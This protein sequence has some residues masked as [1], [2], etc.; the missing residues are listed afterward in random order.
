M[1]RS[2]AISRSDK[3]VGSASP[4][5]AG[6]LLFVTAY[7]R[8]A[9]LLI[10]ALV[11]LGLIVGL[12]FVAWLTN[13]VLVKQEAIAPELIEPLA[14]GGKAFADA[15][16]LA[17][18]GEEELE[19]L[20]E[21]QL[22]ELIDSVAEMATRQAA[23][24]EP[25]TGSSDLSS[26][27][28]GLGD[29][30][31]AGPGTA[32]IIPRW[33]RW[34]IRYPPATIDEYAR[35]LDA[36]GIELAVVGGGTPTVD[37][38]SGLSLPTPKRRSGTTDDRIYF[39]WTRDS[40]TRQADL[41]LLAKAG[42]PTQGRQVLTFIPKPLENALAQLEDAELK[43]RGIRLENVQLTT[44]TLTGEGSSYGFRV[45]EVQARGR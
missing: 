7:E 28:Q 11:L 4:G 39:W 36:L 20:Q 33:E 24:L 27:G 34:L 16:D 15:R 2:S 45:V 12:L 13:R 18:P 23:V 5:P 44:F 1:S 41:A 38:A 8:A 6:N 21:P 43:K 17:D 29:G 32:D 25:R 35:Q 40:A 37:Y 26:R 10:T 42:I 30:R 31:P 19:E 14:G 22:E 3:V 9:A